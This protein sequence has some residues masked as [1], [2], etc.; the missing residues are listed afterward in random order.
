MTAFVLVF[1]PVFTA[2][3]GVLFAAIVALRPPG[4]PLS[5][6]VPQAH[7]DD[8]VVHSAVRRFR[9]S[10]VILWVITAA[11]TVVLALTGQT[12]LATIL[13]VLLYALLSLLALVLSRRAIL[14]AKRDGDWFE[15]IP[16]RVTAQITS[17]AY[18]HPPLVWPALAAIVLAVAAAADVA[19][20][21]TLPDPIPVHFN[22][23]GEPDAWAAKS[24][25][26]V[27]G[28]LLVGAAVVVLLTALSAV[29]AR[30][31]A[32]T[33]S[34]DTADQAALRTRVQRSMLTSLLSQLSFVIAIG[35]SGIELIQR[36]LPGATWTVAVCAIVLVVLVM[37][38][39]IAAVV[40]GRR[41]M[42]PANVR[43]P[44]TPRPDAVDDDQHWRG[45]L[46]YV[47]RDDPALVVPRR[48]G[49]GWTFNL[50]HPGGIAVTV[51]LLLVVAGVVT[52][53]ILLAH[54]Q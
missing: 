15:G 14:R 18:D 21:P 1:A 23:S 54:G 35:I 25:W 47:N 43:D 51:L 10:L 6:R 3:F 17:P 34:D 41:H 26:S 4:L 37:A 44:R 31:N 48:F 16:V 30:Y 13:P 46:L 33:Q 40:R 52:T 11:L 29:A 7:A 38:V 28:L 50:G 42:Q 24:V 9:W 22:F 32:R 12:P 20:Y 27:F 53:V 36:L 45:G 19:L 2:L 5:V 49:L 39:V 8:P